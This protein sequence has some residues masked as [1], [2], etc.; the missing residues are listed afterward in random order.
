MSLRFMHHSS[1]L[2]SRGSVNG[3]P[4]RGGWKVVV[5][6]NGEGDLASER[7]SMETTKAVSPMQRRPATPIP[8]FVLC[9]LAFL[10][11]LGISALRKFFLRFLYPT[12]SD[13]Y[14]LY[15]FVLFS[16]TSSDY[17]FSP[18][19]TLS[20]VFASWCFLVGLVIP[21]DFF[22]TIRHSYSKMAI[23]N[24]GEVMKSLL[25]IRNC[26]RMKLLLFLGSPRELCV[27]FRNLL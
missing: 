22:G 9:H 5:V 16:D 17:L 27:H 13:R 18:V 21:V 6:D 26:L 15:F 2:R 12:I 20:L 24:A 14:L 25:K 7:D 11:L 3:C 4:F 1:P 10:Y 23:G 19:W 8:L